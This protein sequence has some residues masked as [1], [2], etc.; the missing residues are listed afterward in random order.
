M[1]TNRAGLEPIGSI[2]SNRARAKGGPALRLSTY[3]KIISFRAACVV[4]AWG[5]QYILGVS[6]LPT[7]K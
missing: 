4:P 5:P 7:K 3:A 2:A 6:P 1:Y